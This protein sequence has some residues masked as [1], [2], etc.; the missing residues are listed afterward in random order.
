MPY[1]HFP[2]S[3]GPPPPPDS[4]IRNFPQPWRSCH[5][6]PGS[7][8]QLSQLHNVNHLDNVNPE[9]HLSQLTISHV[10]LHQCTLWIKLHNVTMFHNVIHNVELTMWNQGEKGLICTKNGQFVTV[11]PPHARGGKTTFF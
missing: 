9:G 8:E 10:A 2:I 4:R 6:Q 3:L 5:T 7:A 1:C 11:V